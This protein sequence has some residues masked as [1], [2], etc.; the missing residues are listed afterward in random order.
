[1]PRPNNTLRLVL[2]LAFPIL[3]VSCFDFGRNPYKEEIF[4]EAYLPVY[5]L[6]SSSRVI[7]ADMPQPTVD[8]G[9]IYVHGSLLYQVEVY[10]GIHIIDYS[11]KDQPVKLAFI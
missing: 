10:K 1:M 5:G 7:T 4:P 6:D 9:K 8:A 11:N 3:L 2:L